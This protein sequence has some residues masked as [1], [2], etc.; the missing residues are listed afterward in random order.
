MQGTGGSVFEG[1]WITAEMQIKIVMLVLQSYYVNKLSKDAGLT[2]RRSHGSQVGAE[3]CR[4]CWHAAACAS[5][6]AVHLAAPGQSLS[7]P[8]L[9]QE[10]ARSVCND[11]L[12]LVFEQEFTCCMTTNNHV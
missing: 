10:R 1:Y 5:A 6:L 9:M 7:V 12:L 2:Y 8:Q 11:F 3:R 4:A